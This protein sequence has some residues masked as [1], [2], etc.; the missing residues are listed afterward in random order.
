M[1][2]K[3]G[4]WNC[5]I[6]AHPRGQ[7]FADLGICP[8]CFMYEESSFW[9]PGNPPIPFLLK[10]IP[11]SRP[12]NQ[13]PVDPHPP[14]FQYQKK[15][16]DPHPN[17]CKELGTRWDINTMFVGHVQ[18]WTHWQVFNF[19]WLSM[20]LYVNFINKLWERQHLQEN[21]D[22][23]TGLSCGYWVRIVINSQSQ[24]WASDS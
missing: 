14:T 6:S 9:V 4:S 22:C 2:I 7:I 17:V 8:Y 3:D 24:A 20:W 11:W 23:V 18:S 5:M 16:L 12:I 13:P 21:V 15:V 19:Q 10:K 1:T